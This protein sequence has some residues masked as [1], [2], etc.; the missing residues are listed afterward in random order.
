MQI[1]AIIMDGDG[2]TITHTNELPDSLRDLILGNPQIKWIMA[3][4]RSLDLLRQTPIAKYLTN[5]VPHIVDGGSKLMLLNGQSLAEHL[6]EPEELEL[7]FSQ[8]KA[9]DLNFLYYSPDGIIGKAFVANAS[10]QRKFKFTGIDIQ[11]TH[12]INEFSEWAFHSRP[13]KILINAKSSIALDG[14]YYHQNDNNIDVTT[15]G[16]DKGTGCVEL[17]KLL[18]LSPSEA[19]FIF[20]DKNDLPIVE[21]KDLVGLTTIKVGAWLPHIKATFSVNSP[22]EV[23]DIVKQLI[24]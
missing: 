19:V 18:N 9:D 1:K 6:L 11:F 24:S 14:L 3:T 17:L 13:S 15:H 12:S 8:I 16:I 2:S 7:L 23:A 21:H 5:D 10:L 4:G 22:H 20:N